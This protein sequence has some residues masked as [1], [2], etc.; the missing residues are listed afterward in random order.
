MVTQKVTFQPEWQHPRR[1]LLRF[2]QQPVPVERQQHHQAL[3]G[4]FTAPEGARLLFADDATGIASIIQST[5]RHEVYDLQGR[6]V[7]GKPQKGLYIIDGK[8]HT[9]K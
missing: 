9:I 2:G 5:T 3:R 4:Y 8:K 6:K 7:N 1:R